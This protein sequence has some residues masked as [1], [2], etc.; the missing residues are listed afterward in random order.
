V[1]ITVAICTRNRAT[2]LERTLESLVRCVVPADVA[3]EIVVVDNG[4]TDATRTVLDRFAK[5]LPVRSVVE[6][7]PGLS[8]ARNAAVAD[9]RGEYIL[10]TDDDCV[11]DERWIAEYAAAFRRAPGA[12][13]FGGPI[14][15]VF[16][17]GP[18]EWL[19]R[20]A[21]RVGSAYASRDL[22]PNPIP[23]SIAND[24]LPYGANY[25]IRA[26]EQRT[27]LYDETL[28]RGNP[29]SLGEESAVI[30]RLLSEG[31]GGLWIPSAG[32]DHHIPPERQ[33][34]DYLRRHFEG[35]GALTEWRRGRGE[36]NAWTADDTSTLQLLLRLARSEIRYC[37]LRWTAPPEVW[38]EPLLI[39]SIT[40]GRLRAR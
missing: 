39:A 3:W 38:I 31:A 30:E 16:D 24:R 26:P 36:Q 13:V 8:R 12:G 23:L 17:D 15:P 18:P 29:T 21:V 5:R 35:Y 22:G 6:K 19:A 2:S 40:R 1:L 37:V 32:V 9:A 11:V 14:R 10:W 4:S 7:T 33:S 20:V 28:G 27:H 34:V 25:A